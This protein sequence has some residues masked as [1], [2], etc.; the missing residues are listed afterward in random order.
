MAPDHAPRDESLTKRV[1]G[2]DRGAAEGAGEEVGE[3]DPHRIVSET[4]KK[5]PPAAMI[6][7]HRLA[8]AAVPPSTNPYT[9][10]GPAR[11]PRCGHS[12]ATIAIHHA[13]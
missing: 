1:R 8:N 2:H 12:T 7:P 3:K 10:T 9:A 4:R 6:G 11:P 13:M 5:T